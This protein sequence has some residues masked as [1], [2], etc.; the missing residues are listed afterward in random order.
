MGAVIRVL[1]LFDFSTIF[2]SVVANLH[3]KGTL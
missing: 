3:R 2:I 1:S